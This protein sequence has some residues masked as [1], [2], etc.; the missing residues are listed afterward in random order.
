MTLPLGQISM[1][2]VNVELG[3]SA[4]ATISLNDAAVRT[5]AEVPSGAIG[6]NNLQGKSNEFAFTIGSNQANANLRTL[7]VN[8]GW[9]QS[10]PLRATIAGGVW[11]SSTTTGGAALTINGSFPNG[12]TLINNGIISGA[13]GNGGRGGRPYLISPILPVAGS[14]GGGALAVSSAVTIT[15]N[16][17]IQGGGGGGG[18]G[19]GAVNGSVSCNMGD[20]SSNRQ[21]GG[22]GGGG[23]ASNVSFFSS[24]GVGGFTDWTGSCSGRIDGAAG[25][26]GTNGGGGGGGAAGSITCTCAQTAVA[27]A[28]GNGGFWGSTGGSGVSGSGNTG[29]Q[30]G[31][32]GGAGGYAVTGN[33]NIS[34]TA[35]GTRYGSIG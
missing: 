13:G 30:A 22:G 16:G 20:S 35:F 21:P 28:G 18:G 1:S 8:A 31:R 29:T 23:G 26:T 15:N 19:G 9:N 25:G 34:W 33:S 12:V 24:G 5:L 4:T 3:L 10:L 14:A 11:V 7:A 27:G 32:V 17:T 2:Q 6:M